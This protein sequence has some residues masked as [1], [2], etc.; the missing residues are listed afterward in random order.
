MIDKDE[1]LESIKP[2]MDLTKR[3]FWIIYSYELIYP[4]YAEEALCKLE[5]I[6]CMKARVYYAS[7]VKEFMP[8]S[9]EEGKTLSNRHYAAIS[10]RQ[11]EKVAVDEGIAVADVNKTGTDFQIPEAHATVCNPVKSEK[12]TANFD[13]AKGKK[14]AKFAMVNAKELLEMDIPDPE[15]AVEGLLPIGVCLFGG[16]PKSYKSY[17][18]LDM[19]LCICQGRDFLG[20]EAQKS[21]CLYLDLESSERRPRYR[22]KQILNETV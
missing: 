20:F 6:G 4:G 5:K 13:S 7:V 18:C 15:Y 1:L 21:A 9:N 17:M 14:S 22:I 3:V 10:D 11:E 19:C 16:P 2:G 12:A 8:Q